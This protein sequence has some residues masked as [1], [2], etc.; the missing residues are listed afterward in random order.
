VLV[1]K[2]TINNLQDTNKNGDLQPTAPKSIG[3]RV[4][5]GNERILLAFAIYGG[6]AGVITVIDT[7]SFEQDIWATLSIIMNIPTVI[8]FLMILGENFP[9]PVPMELW[10]AT[11]VASS[12]LVWIIIGFIVYCFYRLF[13]LGS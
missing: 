2:D 7:M 5:H 4:F 10:H 3:H 12:A 9:V 11:I 8:A 1:W 13:K 6:V